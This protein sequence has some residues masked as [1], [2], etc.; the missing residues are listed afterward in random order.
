MDLDKFKRQLLEKEQGLLG[1]L[2]KAGE[3]ARE[4]SDGPARDS[5]DKSIENERKDEQ[6][7]STD[8]KWST[9]SQVR[10]ALQRIEDGTFGACLADGE[11]IEEKRLEAI[12]WTRYCVKHQQEVEE[13][14]RTR[15]P[16]L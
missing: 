15:K 6:F 13:T 11:M 7:R 8:A 3:Q 2:V 10:E 4:P 14:E 16:T 9:L 1:G 12:P 5:G